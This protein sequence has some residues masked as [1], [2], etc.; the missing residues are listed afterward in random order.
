[1]PSFRSLNPSVTVAARA[2][3]PGRGDVRRPQVIPADFTYLDGSL[4]PAPPDRRIGTPPTVRIAARCPSV[5]ELEHCGRGRDRGIQQCS[6]PFVD[7]TIRNLRGIWFDLLGQRIDPARTVRRR[8][9]ATSPAAGP[10]GTDPSSW[11]RLQP[12]QVER[13]GGEQHWHDRR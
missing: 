11:A 10:A 13:L 12:R 2:L 5:R 4:H 6:Q 3:G 7:R 1:M 9:S 8:V